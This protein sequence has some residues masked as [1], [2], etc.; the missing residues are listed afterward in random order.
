MV[1]QRDLP[2]PHLLAG[3][4]PLAACLALLARPHPSRPLPPLDWSSLEYLLDSAH[5]NSQFVNIIAR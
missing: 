4:G 5:N 1:Q 3:G 2:R